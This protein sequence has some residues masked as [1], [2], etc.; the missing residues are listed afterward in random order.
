MADR[1][2]LGQGLPFEERIALAQLIL[3]PGW[4][5]LVRIMAEACRDATE[6]V[7][8]LDPTTE[9]YQERLAGL[10]TTARAMNKFSADVLDSV[11]V[12]KDQAIK[13]AQARENPDV[14]E[15]PVTRFQGFKPPKAKK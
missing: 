14:V 15:K 2:L 5:V 9:R 10:Q 1:K 12:H 4:T 8:R 3:Q 11:K 7:V 6:S 13:D